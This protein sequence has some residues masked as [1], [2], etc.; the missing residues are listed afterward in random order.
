MIIDVHAHCVPEG[1]EDELRRN[2]PSYGIELVDAGDRPAV[3]IAD[4]ITTGPLRDFLSDRPRRREA[5]DVGEVDVQLISSWID[6]TAYALPAAAGRRWARCLN[7]FLAAEADVT[8]ARLRA[9]ATVPL[10]DPRAAADELRHAVGEL[11]MA[12]VEIS[13][14]VDGRDLDDRDLEPFWDA[15]EETKA[16]VLL[17][18]YESL[19]GRDLPRYFLKNLV[20]NPAES[21]IAVAHLIFGGVLERHP[22]LR[23]CVVHGGGFAPYQIGRWRRGFAAVPH[24]THTEMGV[25]PLES[26]RRLYFDTVLHDSAALQHLLGVAGSERMVLGSDFP[27]E[28]GDPTPVVTV[29]EA[30]ADLPDADMDAILGGNV[31]SLLDQVGT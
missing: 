16:F 30:L 3:Q 2:G 18:P 12:G 17:H 11:G 1:L 29:R 28:M 9:L 27:F 14:S 8:P 19:K 22:G 21:T 31:E 13:T 23:M 25:D 15:A 4:R 7:E 20:G 6:L 24:L 26:F 5:M 10:Q